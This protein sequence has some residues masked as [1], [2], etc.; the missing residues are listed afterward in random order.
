MPIA[1]EV[2]TVLWGE[3]N[4]AAV[5]HFKD[6]HEVTLERYLNLSCHHWATESSLR[7]S[8]KLAG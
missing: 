3:F 6:G 8:R 5:V 7:R 1:F 4:V 2:R